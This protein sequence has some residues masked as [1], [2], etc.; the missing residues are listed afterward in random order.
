LSLS[1][2]SLATSIKQDLGL[3]WEEISEK[4]A[5]LREARPY[6]FFTKPKAALG[7]YVK[8]ET[9]DKILVTC[10]VSLSY[11]LGKTPMVFWI[12]ATGFLF[13][14]FSLLW[15]LGQIRRIRYCKSG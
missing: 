9:E 2:A 15:F 1:Q 8:L 12:T 11:Q 4:A 13:L 3:A 10:D 14:L 5:R 7:K 6:F